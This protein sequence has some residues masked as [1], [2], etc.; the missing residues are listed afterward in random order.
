MLAN[1]AHWIGETLSRLQSRELSPV[2]NV[3]SATATFREQVQPWIDRE[4]FSPL[5]KRGVVIEHLDIQRG[6]GVDLCG[7]LDDDNFVGQL[8]SRGYQSLLCCNLLEHVNDPASIASKLETIL[9][10]GGHLIV[11]VP[12]QFPYHP[13]PIDTMFRPSVYEL[14]NLF[15]NCHLLQ[16]TLLDCGTGWDYV[17]RNPLVM[18]SKLKH[19]F[20]GLR[21]HGGIR[22]SSSFVPW[23]FR[24]FRQTCVLLQKKQ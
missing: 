8:F 10:S 5:R 12:N 7:D 20:K 19:R 3:G 22:G 16:G 11:T 18:L 1:E 23:L 14:S 2:L 21:D 4:I 15:A 17:G 6:D 9:P 13:D 24:T